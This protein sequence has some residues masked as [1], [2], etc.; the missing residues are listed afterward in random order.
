MKIH[1]L[2][3]D[4]A[5]ASLRTSW[6]GLDDAEAR[7]RLA[8]YG[9]NRV[10]TQRRTPAI[11]LLTREFTHFFALVLWLAAA[12]AWVAEANDPGKGMATLAGAI[13]GVIIVNGV[14]SYWQQFRTERVLAALAR[15]LPHQARAVRG[16]EIVL[17][18]VAELV[19]GDVILV[20]GGDDVPADCRVIEAFGLRVNTATV[21]GESFAKARHAAP[22]PEEDDPLHARNLLLAGTSVIAGE[23]RALVFAT[24]MATEFGRIARL[25][26]ATAEEPSPLQREIV[27]LSRII[28]AVATAL[29]VLFFLVGEILGLSFW[30]N[31][32]FAIGIIV[33]MV[34]EGLLPTLTLSLAFAAQRMARRNA[35]VRHLAAV[36]ALGAASVICSDKT[37][38]LTE[39][40][41]SVERIYT[42]G[43]YMDCS[44]PAVPGSALSSLLD[45]A[46]HCHS[47][48]FVTMNGAV[49]AVGDPM[50]IALVR[51]ARSLRA[52]KTLPQVDE[53]PF[54]AD[55]RRM[56]T[57]HEGA[58]GR[59][60]HCKGAPEAVLPLCTRIITDRGE[61][62]LDDGRRAALIEA[63]QRMAEEGLRVLA[64]AHGVV[65]A[66]TPREGW[67]SDLAASGLVGLKDPPRPEVPEA[68]RRCH[69]AGIRVV[70]I[71][72]DHPATALAIAREL[73]IAG[74][75]PHVYTGEELRRL[76]D[77]QLQLVLDAP[78][79]LFARMGPEQK[80][81]VVN[82]F[83]RKG[84]VVAVTGDG[85]NDAPALKAADIGIA[86]GR[87]GTDVARE[88]ADVVLLDDN[89]ASI[90]AAIEEGR[91]VFD[92][93]RKFMTY[94]LTSNVPEIVPYL[95]FV[96]FRI[97][98]PLTI[99]QI[100]AVDLGTDMLPALALG[101][102]KPD[103]DVMQR[104]PRRPQERLLDWGLMA[105]AFL[106]LGPIQAAAALAAFFFVLYGGGWCYGAQLAAGDP[107]YLTATTACLAAIVAM[108]VAN[109]FECRHPYKPAWSRD[110]GANRLIAWGIAFEIA[111][112]L[113]IVYTPWGQLA[114]GT[115]AL[116]VAIWLFLAPCALVLIVLEE[117]RKA[118]A[119]RARPRPAP[120]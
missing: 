113:A 37:G 116:P 73:G 92:N 107:L 99:I 44:A 72:G 68:I 6:H 78:D 35:L 97:P 59:V 98:L 1:H 95:A 79:V 52:D 2:T 20:E 39:N 108:Q 109:V 40:T 105:R 45:T 14:F 43:G 88:A 23:A 106:F 86:M 7:R 60:L 5:L 34:P 9:L 25:T 101:A 70:M 120:R 62:P 84:H 53:I 47:L 27:R 13:V 90:A 87:R 4:Q 3:A 110:L 118:I 112:L 69:A 16:G 41:M 24:G 55:R 61:I 76:S 93:V 80:L 48:K 51:A 119:Y 15:L 71:T 57:L 91:A 10:E 94:I 96:L 104:P 28:A 54:D 65:A 29:G 67:E 75:A 64:F 33:A 38:T 82:A 117:I 46:L 114:F 111:L 77:T 17:L 63:Q 18:P 30:E 11:L 83:R 22:T 19:P 12:L 103:P 32:V 26:Q 89:F 100:L 36:E 49:E 56:S 115:A 102:E 42:D 85:V 58:A 8:E 81:R 31:F 50:E 74:A 66:D 21:T